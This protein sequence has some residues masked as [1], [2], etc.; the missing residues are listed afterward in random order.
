MIVISHCNKEKHLDE[1]KFSTVRKNTAEYFFNELS[2]L[3]E[4]GGKAYFFL[5]LT[6]ITIRYQKKTTEN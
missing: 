2:Y 5:I 4:R 1:L 3:L 6:S